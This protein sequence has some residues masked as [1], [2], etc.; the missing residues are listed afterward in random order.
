MMSIDAV[1]HRGL[2]VPTTGQG[3][4]IG[5]SIDQIRRTSSESDFL[6]DVDADSAYSYSSA[7]SVTGGPK[8]VRFDPE[9]D[10]RWDP[11]QVE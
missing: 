8:F 11:I 10:A 6:R 2:T 7:V 4:L 3:A 1:T 5:G 9:S